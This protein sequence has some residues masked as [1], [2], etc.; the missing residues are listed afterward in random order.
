MGCYQHT[1]LAAEMFAK[2]G[3]SQGLSNTFRKGQ[4]KKKLKPTCNLNSLILCSLK[5]CVTCERFWCNIYVN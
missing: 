1:N 3:I 4:I 2:E 5:G